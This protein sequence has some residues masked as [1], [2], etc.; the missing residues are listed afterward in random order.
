MKLE[1]KYSLKFTQNKTID[2]NFIIR[3]ISKEY[4]LYFNGR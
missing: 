1:Y 4:I 3:F 2:N